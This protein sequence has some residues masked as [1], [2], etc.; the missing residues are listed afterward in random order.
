M[1]KHNFHK[2]VRYAETDKMGYLYYGHYPKYYEIGRVELIR[3]LGFR[4]R[5]FEDE[6][7]VML[8][9][10]SMEVRYLL[11]AYYDDLLIIESTVT[12]M[13]TKLI[14]FDFRIINEEEKVINTATVKLFF[15]DMNTNKRVSCPT[16]FHN[17]LNQHFESV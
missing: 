11:P 12:E 14:N 5:D 2:R 16:E 13:P 9:V 1:Y 8:P 15:I 10:V 3:S 4:Y 17:V 7:G 6:L